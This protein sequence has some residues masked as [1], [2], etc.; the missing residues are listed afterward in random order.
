MRGGSML[1]KKLLGK[2][3]IKCILI[4]ILLLVLFNM[5]FANDRPAATFLIIPPGAKALG[6]GSAFTGSWD[7]PSSFYYNPGAIGLYNKFG[8]SL[9]NQG[10]PPGIGRFIEQGILALSGKVLYNEVIS[11]EPGW[12]PHLHPDMRYVNSFYAIPFRNIGTLGINFVYLNTGETEVLD[13]TGVYLG[14]YE[15]YDVATGLS[16]GRSFFGKLGLGFT[17]KYI[18]SFL[19]PDWVWERM[20]GLGIEKG[21]IGT[22]WAVDI[23]ALYRIW[24]LGVGVSLQNFGTEIRYTESDLPNRVPT[25]IRGGISIQPL[26]ALDSLYSLHNYKF[27]NIPVSDIL[28]I[29]FNYDRAYDPE[30]LDDTWVCSGWEFTLFKILSYRLGSWNI[31]S[32]RSSGFGL[33]LRNVE[34][35][36]ARYFDWDTYHVQMT[37]HAIKPPEKIKNNKKLNTTLILASASLVPG[38]GQFYKGEGTKASLF[39]IPGLYLGNSYLT[40]DSKTTKTWALIGLGVLYLGS[41]LEAMLND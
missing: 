26:V 21:G 29:T 28:N 24:G 30:Q 2:I 8:F 23:G 40:S 36:V 39:F 18:Y 9:V 32:R 19:V 15:T 25:R 4:T 38:G 13:E 7:D 27:F 11:P 22:A 33:K 41:A 14:T 34:I 17:A 12:L 10:L 31:W 20:P 35:D 16:Y 3:S 1:K 5:P 37:F 6:M